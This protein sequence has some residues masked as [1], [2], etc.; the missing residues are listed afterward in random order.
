MKSKANTTRILSSKDIQHIVQHIGINKIVD[1]LLERTTTAIKNYSPSSTLIPVRAGFNYQHPQV[2]LIEWMPLYKRDQEIIIKVVGYHPNNP[3]INNLPTIL[4]T[5]SSYDSSSGHLIGIVDGVFL[6]AIRTGV[7]SAI[8]SRALANPDSKTLGLIG[9]GAQ[10]ITQ[11]HALSRY[12]ELE[13]VLIYDTDV[14][15]MLSFSDRCQT[16]NCQLSIRTSTI[17]EMVSQSDI[18]CT[19]TSIDVGEGPLFK[20]LPTKSH[21]HINAVGADFPGKF[22]LPLDYLAQSFVCPD[23]EAQAIIEGECQRLEKEQIG[24]DLAK[25]IQNAANYL[26]VQSQ[27]S[28]FDSTG[29]ALEDQIVM[30][31]FMDYANDLG[32]GQEIEIEMISENAKNPYYFLNKSE[33]IS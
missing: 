19:A 25:V 15:T 6:T 20:G 30:E 32:V 33:P 29:W 10:A 28:V 24:P 4:S 17:E 22:E 1:A 21:L 3:V 5:I 23:F 14:E 9:C 11:L 27:R 2:G 13:E 12:F 8:A 7:A 16:F 26:P 31:Q 18:L